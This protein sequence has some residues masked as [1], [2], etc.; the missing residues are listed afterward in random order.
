MRRLLT[1][2][3]CLILT[4]Q[5]SWA[6]AANYCLHE[7]AAQQSAHFGH[8]SD[9]HVHAEMA[10][11]ADMKSP[12]L[13]ADLDHGHCHLPP[14]LVAEDAEPRPVLEAQPAPLSPIPG[15]RESHVPDGLERPNWL[16]A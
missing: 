16:R 3:L 13:S 12:T 2:F 4:A 10:K 15:Q 8:H 1:V 9:A 11:K 7:A 14:V 5:F 6:A